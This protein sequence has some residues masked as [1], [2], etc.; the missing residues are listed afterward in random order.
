M[1][2]VVGAFMSGLGRQARLPAPTSPSA[3]SAGAPAEA[4]A[5]A[6]GLDG[7]HEFFGLI[8]KRL[9]AAILVLDLSNPAGWGHPAY[10]P[11]KPPACRPGALTRRAARGHNETSPNK[12]ALCPLEP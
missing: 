10:R 2:F 6:Q 4:S 9:A 12:C 3:P 5:G 7:V 8:Q 11:R 1:G